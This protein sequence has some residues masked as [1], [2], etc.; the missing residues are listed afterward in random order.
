MSSR[1]TRSTLRRA[2]RRLALLALLAPALA[3][4]TSLEALFAPK[5]ELWARWQAHDP[6]AATAVDHGPWDR[7]LQAYVA[8][9]AAGVNRFDYAGV[10]APDR[11]A[12]DGYVAGLA[13]LPVS[14]YARAEQLAYWINLYNALTVQVVLAHYP[15]ESIRDIDIS[16]GL[17]ADGPWG[18]A[19]LEIEG[20]PVSLNDIEH[21]ILRPIWRDPRIHYALNCAA[22]GCPDLQ[23]RAFTAATSEALLEAAARAFVNSPRGARFENNGLVVSSIYVWFG[24]DFGGGDSGVIAHLR[25]YAEPALAARLA[26]VDKLG[27]HA[28]DWTLNGRDGPPA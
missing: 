2:A 8:P 20:E 9:D 13:A 4:L 7:I 23:R 14:R 5:A 27:G 26:G 6:S 18:K 3:G 15:V 25:R 22:L 24:E 12:L 16:P 17:F 21:R 28:Y 11:A 19:L 1:I 10:S